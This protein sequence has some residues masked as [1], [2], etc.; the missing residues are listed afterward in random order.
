[1]YLG[2][3]RG[4]GVFVGIFVRFIIQPWTT[5]MPLNKNFVIGHSPLAEGEGVDKPLDKPLDGGYNI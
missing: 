3:H 4:V 2:G 1:M 5:L